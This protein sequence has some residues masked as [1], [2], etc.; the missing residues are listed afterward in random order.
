NLAA[1]VWSAV[2]APARTSQISH[3]QA[4]GNVSGAHA[5]TSGPTNHPRSAF[6]DDAASTTLGE[7]LPSSTVLAFEQSFAR[8]EAPALVL[9]EISIPT[10]IAAR[11][12]PLTFCMS[13]YS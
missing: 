5:L 4:S 12:H 7:V 8:L 13:L 10:G 6:I 2:W 1:S 11:L 3:G 9:I